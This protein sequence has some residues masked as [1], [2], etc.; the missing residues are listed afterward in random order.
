VGL[1]RG[2]HNGFTLVELMIVV[3]IISIL[4]AVAIPSYSSYVTRSKVVEATSA[5]SGM[6]VLMEQYYQDNRTYLNGAVCGTIGAV[7]T[8]TKYFTYACQAAA[9]TYTITASGSG[10]MAGFGYTVDQGNNKTS[11]ITAPATA[12]G[13]SNPNP[14]TCWTTN[15]G[16]Q[17]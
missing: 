11:N 7:P 1:N 16:G 6:R 3:T 12:K 15:K 5:L 9:N 13:W 17:C 2:F 4:A 14:N 10:G 8:A